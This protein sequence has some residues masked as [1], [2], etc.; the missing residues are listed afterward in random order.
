MESIECATLR[1]KFNNLGVSL[2]KHSAHECLT[3]SRRKNWIIFIFA[4]LQQKK[5][6]KNL[7]FELILKTLSPSKYLAKSFNI[8]VLQETQCVSEEGPWRVS[9]PKTEFFQLY[10]LLIKD[11]ASVN[12]SCHAYILRLPG[13]YQSTIK[14]TFHSRS[15]K[16]FLCY[17]SRGVKPFSR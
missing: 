1:K 17:W 12:N 11:I 14:N 3:W 9:M 8:I 4:L 13:L 10:Q 15:R 16:E 2:N 5:R 6:E 7:L